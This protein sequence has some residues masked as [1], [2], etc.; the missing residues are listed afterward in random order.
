MRYPILSDPFLQPP[1]STSTFP[2]TSTGPL[3][4]LQS[5]LS[6]SLRMT[7][8]WHGLLFTR[9]P[10]APRL[11]GSSMGLW[12]MV[13]PLPCKTFPALPTVSCP[14]CSS[15]AAIG[16]HFGSCHFGSRPP[17][18]QRGGSGAHWQLVLFASK[19]RRGHMPRKGWSTVQVPD[20]WLQL[21]RGPRPQSAKWPMRKPKRRPKCV[22]SQTG[23]SRRKCSSNGRRRGSSLVAKRFPGLRRFRRQCRQSCNP[24]SMGWPTPRLDWHPSSWRSPMGWQRLHQ[25]SLPISRRSWPSCVLVS[26]I[27]RGKTPISIL[28]CNSK[29]KVAKN[30]ETS[31]KLVKFDT[32]FGTTTPQSR[33]RRGLHGAECATVSKDCP[34]HLSGWTLID[35]AEVSVR[36]NRF[37]PL[38]S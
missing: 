34:S 27:C 5:T 28:N 18:L 13:L 1:S 2:L 32:R 4:I 22:P 9:L 15:S 33:S 36:S 3:T 17:L 16:S 12:F 29:V 11:F 14:Q 25:P 19:V 38:S 30:G 10:K 37:N 8:G 21:I 20:G 35:N 24:K 6:V 31:E 23:S 26:S 7:A